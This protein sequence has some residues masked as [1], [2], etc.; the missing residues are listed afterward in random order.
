MIKK[1]VI[2]TLS[3]LA[4]INAQDKKPLTLEDIFYNNTF[5]EHPIENIQ[6]QPNGKAF[7]FTK[8]NTQTGDLEIYIHDVS[9]GKNTLLVSRD[10]L[11]YNSELIKM[12][13]YQWT[14]D[15]KYFLIAGPSESIWRHSTQAPYF[16][17]DVETKEITVLANN[18]KHLRNVKLSPDGKH[19]GYVRNHNIYIT[20][21]S[22]GEEKAITSN[23]S[24]NI[25]NGEFDWVYEE[26]FSLADAWRWSP[27]SKKIAF[28]E[29]DQSRVKEFYLIDE[30]AP[31]NKIYK[32]KYPKV[33]EQN[34]IVRIGVADVEKD[35]TIFMGIGG[36][37]DIY[38]PRIFW[39]NS[40]EL[41]SILRLNRRQNIA[42]LLMANTNTGKSKVIITDTDSAWVEVT[43]DISFLKSKDQ[44]IFSSEKS[45]YRHAYLYNYDGQLIKQITDGGWEITE[46]SGVDE[47]NNLL[48]FYGKKDSPIEQ[49]IYRIKL[50]GTQLSKISNGHGWHKPIFSPDYKYFIDNYSSASTPP[51][52]SLNKS[53]GTEI[54]IL[55]NGEIDAL[56][57]YDIT[58]PEFVT[59]TTT[60]TKLNGYFIKPYDFSS[61]KKY[62]VLVY[63]YGG[64]GSQKVIDKWPDAQRWFDHY[65]ASH[66]YIVFCL[67]NRGTGGRGKEF[68]NL[69]YG[70]LS[71]WSI[72]DQVEGAKYLATLNYVDKNRLAFWGWSGGAYLTL[73]M[74][75]RGADYFK[76]GVAVAPVSDFYTYDAPWAERQMGLP[77]ENAKGYENANHQNFVD[78]LK[79][80]LLI[81]HGTGDDNV[82]YQNTLQFIDKCIKKNKQVDMFLYPNKN[83]FIT[84]GYTRLNLF[85]KIRNY[86]DCNL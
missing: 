60:D 69:S 9:S 32:L 37:D 77:S 44:I 18:D 25:L 23:G 2:I 28:W 30:M 16:L 86:F 35:K 38:I 66:G 45:G 41:L 11:I 49:H 58:Y 72:H 57:N 48:Y 71:K 83:H 82:H 40:S 5:A 65:M 22:T 46:I 10:E 33:G 20:D 84:G 31:Y 55:N 59:I 14:A 36:N 73:G 3:F 54:R 15:G 27:D 53:D 26:E 43:H 17:L 8:G 42:E 12:S 51:A 85:T 81:I 47:K 50:D 29:F 78:L 68:K 13:S 6:W 70:D 56:K 63:G 1:F 61:D 80:K 19:V 76:V 21:L 67:D 64:P 34:S 79:G 7:T 24:D 75:T 4:F 74:L 62:P 52:S 39:T